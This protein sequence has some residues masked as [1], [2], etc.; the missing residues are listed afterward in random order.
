MDCLS[1]CRQGEKQDM[2][3]KHVDIIGGNEMQSSKFFCKRNDEANLNVRT[4]DAF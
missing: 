2:V 1:A 3:L 4:R